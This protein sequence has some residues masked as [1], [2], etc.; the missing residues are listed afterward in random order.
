MSYG[1][2]PTAATQDYSSS[3][4]D[5][6]LPPSPGLYD[7][8]GRGFQLEP[9]ALGSQPPTSSGTPFREEKPNTAPELLPLSSAQMEEIIER[10]LNAAIQKLAHK[11]LP[12]MA[13]KILKDEIHKM[14]A[15]TPQDQR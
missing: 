7:H 2:R 5:P 14:L 12:D 3:R 13:E 10:Q 15:E 1:G 8:G 6:S 11:L 9:P 4:P